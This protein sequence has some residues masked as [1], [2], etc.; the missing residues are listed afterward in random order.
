MLSYGFKIYRYKKYFH[1]QIPNFP[2]F[3]ENSN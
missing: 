1:V 3:L 2:D